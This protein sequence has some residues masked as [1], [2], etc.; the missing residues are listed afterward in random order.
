MYSSSYIR[1]FIVFNTI[2]TMISKVFHMLLRKVLIQ[3]YEEVDFCSL[4]FDWFI[5][6]SLPVYVKQPAE[7]K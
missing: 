7:M 3:L 1:I 5:F 6:F 4:F 2:I